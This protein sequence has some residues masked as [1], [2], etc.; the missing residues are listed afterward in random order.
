MHI[1]V[2][3]VKLNHSSND[4]HHVVLDTAVVDMREKLRNYL[5]G[6]VQYS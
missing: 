2:K 6:S 1:L 4:I 5:N 3:K